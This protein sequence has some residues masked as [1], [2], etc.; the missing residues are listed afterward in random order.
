LGVLPRSPERCEPPSPDNPGVYW[1][2]G[3]D[4]ILS[5][6]MPSLFPGI[7]D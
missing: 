4:R 6:T 5:L 3:V 2:C 1:D 7:Q